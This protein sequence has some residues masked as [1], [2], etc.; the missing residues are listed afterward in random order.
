MKHCNK[1]NCDKEIN[2]FGKDKTHRDGHASVCLECCRKKDKE[3]A[4]LPYRIA[5]MKSDKM[6]E[7]KKNYNKTPQRKSHIRNYENT[8]R[9][10]PQVRIAHNLRSMIRFIVQRPSISKETEK[11][12]GCTRKQ[13]LDYQ[14]GLFLQGM[15]FD[16]YGKVW[17]FDHIKPLIKF[18]LT[19]EHDYNVCCHYTNIQPLFCN[20][21]KE[22]TDRV[23]IDEKNQLKMML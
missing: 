18:D 10:K 21:N 23:L 14:Q 8:H 9:Q 12:I 6:R 5:Q 19:N 11:L 22:K 3:R 16:N 1:C 13:F 2:E 20:E 17:E 15:T 4:K 7:W